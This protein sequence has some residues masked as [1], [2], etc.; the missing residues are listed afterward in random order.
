MAEGMKYNLSSMAKWL[1]LGFCTF[2]CFC[3]HI[4][5]RL[6]N[7]LCENTLKETFFLDWSH[8]IGV[9]VQFDWQFGYGN[10]QWLFKQRW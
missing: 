9:L 4:L 10:V 2:E 7:F 8:Q 5:A 1:L 6:E 3:G